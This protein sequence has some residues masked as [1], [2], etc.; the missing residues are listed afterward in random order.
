MKYPH[1]GQEID[2]DLAQE[3]FCNECGEEVDPGDNK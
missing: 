2:E 1:C 3:G